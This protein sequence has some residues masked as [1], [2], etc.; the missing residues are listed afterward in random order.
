MSY[1]VNFQCPDSG[2]PIEA[3][4]AFGRLSVDLDERWLRS[5][6]GPENAEGGAT[7]A[8][9]QDALEH[10]KR[11]IAQVHGRRCPSVESAQ[12]ELER[13]GVHGDY[14]ERD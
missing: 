10:T 12:A 4:Y 8:D 13:Y 5:V 14:L 9:Y 11:W 7:E 3:T 2:L 1:R 6:Y